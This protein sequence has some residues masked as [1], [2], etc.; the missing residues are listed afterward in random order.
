MSTFLKYLTKEKLLKSFEDW[1]GFFILWLL[2]SPCFPLEDHCSISDFYSDSD[3]S[4]NFPTLHPERKPL[5][6]NSL[7]C[8][9]LHE[10]ITLEVK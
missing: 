5:Q 4:Q 7:K 10:Y 3:L 9:F 8:L 2:I 1:R 6:L